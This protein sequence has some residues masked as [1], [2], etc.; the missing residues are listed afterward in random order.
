CCHQG[1]PN[2]RLAASVAQAAGTRSYVGDA[3]LDLV[4]DATGL[5]ALNVGDVVLVFQQHPERVVHQR[6]VERGLIQLYECIDP[7]DG[8]GHTRHLEQVG[9]AQALDKRHHLL[10]QASAGV[11]RL[12]LHDG[13]FAFGVGVINPVVQATTLDGVVDFTRAI[14]GDDDNRALLGANRANLGHGYLKIRQQF[15]QVGLERLV[16][17]IE[18]V[19][20][21]YK[22]AFHGGFQCLQ[23]G[24]ANQKAR[25]K[26][27]FAE[28]L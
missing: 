6:R 24:A 18:L 21:Q 27:F 22:Q 10:L 2:A 5:F 7:V 11:G 12:D 1:G 26:D 9:R 20:Q 4:E 25:I 23:Q 14:G 8:F 28:A 19:N 13:A 3:I 16:G 15:Q 17:P